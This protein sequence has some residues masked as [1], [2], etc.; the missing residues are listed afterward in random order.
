[1]GT[2]KQG[3]LG[4]FNGKVGTVVGSSWK[5][6]AY[7]RGLAQHVKNPKTEKQLEQRHK[8]D[9]AQKFMKQALQFINLGLK[10][11][12][13]KQSPFNY[14]VRQMVNK[15]IGN[16]PD[17]EIDFSKVILSHG[18]LTPPSVQIMYVT[19]TERTREIGLR[20]AIGARRR[21]IMMQFLVES[22]VL[23]LA[24][25]FFGAL[26]GIGIYAIACTAAKLPFVFNSGAMLLSFAVCTVVGV[27]FG[28]YPAR[29]AAALDPTQALR[30]E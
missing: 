14:A 5:G 15:A 29:K 24:G 10:D 16:A 27:F 9:I 22:V 4:G 7:M 11:V 21:N 26:L 18:I 30:Y 2:I 12:A 28:W 13:K 23:S 3:I 6:E 19:V 17:Y 8:M 1:M 20:K 25:G